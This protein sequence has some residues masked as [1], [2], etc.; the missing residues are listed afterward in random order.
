MRLFNIGDKVVHTTQGALGK[1]ITNKGE[2]S[3]ERQDNRGIAGYVVS[4]NEAVSYWCAEDTLCLDNSL[5]TKSVLTTEIVPT[6]L[7]VMSESLAYTPINI[8][9][10]KAKFINYALAIRDKYKGIVLTN[11]NESELKAL[12]T[13]LGKVAKEINAERLRIQREIDAP[14]KQFKLDVDEVVKIITETQTTIKVQLDESAQAKRDKKRQ[15]VQVILDGFISGSTLPENYLARVTLKDEYLNAVT[16][17]K[18][19][20]E[21]IQGQIAQLEED[22]ANELKAQEAEVERIRNRVAMYETLKQAYPTVELDFAALTHKESHEFGE[23]FNNKF[24]IQKQQEAA[25]QQREAAQVEVAVFQMP[26]KVVVNEEVVSLPSVNT[27]MEIKTHALQD[28]PSDFHI[29]Q[30]V[31]QPPEVVSS[32]QFTGKV[33]YMDGVHYATP[34]QPHAIDLRVVGVTE[35]STLNAVLAIIS[36]AE[37]QGLTVELLTQI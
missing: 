34:A 13:A 10:D 29:Q 15:E 27:V 26:S 28:V 22:R 12:S 7:P 23:V 21:D 9:F 3:S 4:F 35:E 19:I 16:S 6:E 17:M 18:K 24:Q 31:A 14:V 37:Q 20:K 1:I 33:V 2:I 11:D 36:L 8:N 30:F 25:R 32:P 5:E